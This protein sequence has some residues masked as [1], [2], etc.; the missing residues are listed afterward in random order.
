VGWESRFGKEELG[1]ENWVYSSDQYIDLIKCHPTLDTI[2]PT[3]RICRHER[4]GAIPFWLSRSDKAKKDDDDFN[5]HKVK[6]DDVERRTSNGVTSKRKRTT[7]TPKSI[8]SKGQRRKSEKDDIEHG[9]TG[10][11]FIVSLLVFR[12]PLIYR[13]LSRAV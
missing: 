3:N 6:K 4:K 9:H 5:K 8:T 11:S 1:W 7:T 13:G 10:R 12:L 2:P